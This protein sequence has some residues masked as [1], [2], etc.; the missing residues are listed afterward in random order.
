MIFISVATA[1]FSG[2][3]ISN[4][5]NVFEGISNLTLFY[6]L[7]LA[8]FFVSRIVLFKKSRISILTVSKTSKMFKGF[9]VGLSF[10]LTVYG[11]I[12][13]TKNINSTLLEF[14]SSFGIL[15]SGVALFTLCFLSNKNRIRNQIATNISTLPIVWLVYEIILIFK[16]NLSNPNISEYIFPILLYA[17]TSVAFYYYSCAF[18]VVS[19]KNLFKEHFNV[20]IFILIGY[21]IASFNGHITSFDI[22]LFVIFA[23]CSIL[24]LFMFP[25]YLTELKTESEILDEGIDFDE[26][27]PEPVDFLG[28]LEKNA[29]KTSELSN[30]DILNEPAQKTPVISDDTAQNTDENSSKTKSATYDMI[31]EALSKPFDDEK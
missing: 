12:D 23:T 24:N 9:L 25:F 3:L 1:I 29:I 17:S 10:A 5:S 13:L 16:N 2:I 27:D 8:I 14:I 28:G 6:I 20:S 26:N 18:C 30:L 4:A 21:A 19:K 11:F 31:K 7:S 15:I 22:D